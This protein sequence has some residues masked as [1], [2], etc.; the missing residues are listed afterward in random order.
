[1]TRARLLPAA[2]LVGLLSFTAGGQPPKDK[3]APPK[4]YT[5]N[6][7]EDGVQKLR[8]ASCSV[9]YEEPPTD[10]GKARRRL[11]ARARFAAPAPAAAGKADKVDIV[12]F[13]RTVTDDQLARLVPFAQRLPGLKAVDLGQCVH[14]T[15]AGLKEVA[16]LPHLQALLLD[17][18]PV[19]RDGL[20][21]LAALK[22]LQF[23]DLSNTTVADRDVAALADF[24]SLATLHLKN[25]TNVTADGVA[26]LQKITLLR[27]LHLTVSNDP[28]GMMAEVGKLRLTELKAYP[29]TDDEAKEV[30]K[31]TGL[32]VLDVGHYPFAEYDAYQW[33]FWRGW[34][35]RGEKADTDEAATDDAMKAARERIE[36]MAKGL[37]GVKG[38]G[39][40]PLPGGRHLITAK[41]LTEI[42]KC[43]NLRVLDLSGHP[44]DAST[45]DLH[46]LEFLQELDLTGTRFSDAGAPW[47][48][49]LKAL[50]TLRL[51]ATRLTTDGV[52][53]LAYAGGLEVLSLDLL[54]I[55]DEAIGYLARNRKLRELSVNGT[56]VACADRKALGELVRLEWFEVADTNVTDGTLM[57][58]V[59]LKTLYWVNA[60]MNCPNVTWPGALAVQGQLGPDAM[61]VANPCEGYWPGGGGVPVVRVPVGPPSRTPPSVTIKSPLPSV[62]SKPAPPPPIRP[63]TVGGS[64]K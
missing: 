40:R 12:V 19:D 4:A 17:G 49:K 39:R 54:P 60:T 8:D 21:H 36:K 50:K 56:R 63:V 2:A 53:E 30:G 35:A 44:I 47:L 9:H 42:V 62:A 26:H 14:V 18:C 58:L 38:P 28:P 13:P 10:K 7:M 61:V 59:P 37:P 55:G 43:A 32:E 57:N 34:Q 27:V 11:A 3:P 25:V 48:G 16:K 41:G 64:I 52:R 45:T 23:L 20:A 46:K 6:Q 22:K 51:G 1:M 31:L 33:G 5:P 29:I 24:P 15:A